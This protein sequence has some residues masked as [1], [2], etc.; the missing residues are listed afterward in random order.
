M[1]NILKALSGKKSLYICMTLAAIATVMEIVTA[2]RTGVTPNYQGMGLYWFALWAWA[3]A[4][5]EQK[6]DISHSDL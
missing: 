1:K 4:I 3:T 6:K 2:I 5:E